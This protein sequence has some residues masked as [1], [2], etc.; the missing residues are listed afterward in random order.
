[1][2]IVSLLGGP[3]LETAADLFKSYQEGN[4][5]KEQLSFEINTLEQRHKQELKLAQISVNKQEAQG[6]WFQAGWR[7][8]M[9]Y[10]CV[11]GF[12]MNFLVIPVGMAFG[13]EVS[14]LD[15]SEMLPVLFGML[16]LGG[17]RTYEKV[18]NSL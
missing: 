15:L 17:F 9:G 1:M 16:G 4:L 5:T 12:M 8:L 18:K 3:L 6:N 2:S 10:T 14:P 7:P 13:L 11:L